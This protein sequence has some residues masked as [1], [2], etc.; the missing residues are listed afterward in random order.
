MKTL[1]AILLLAAAAGAQIRVVQL[2][3]KSPLVTFRL[4]F[5]TGAAADPVEKP[6]LAELTASMI[7]EGGTKDM[8]YKQIEDA[9]FP[10]AASLGVQVDKEM[11]AFIGETHVDNLAAYFSA[12]EI[13]IVKV[14]GG[15]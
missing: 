1:A 5:T 3:G 14:P 9:L 13:R 2:P 15:Q 11:T 4:V 7:A 12:I 6:G 10:M 8:T